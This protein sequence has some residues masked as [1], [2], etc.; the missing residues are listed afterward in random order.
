M[1]FFLSAKSKVDRARVRDWLSLAFV[2]GKAD[3]KE[4]ALIALLAKEHGVSKADVDAALNDPK[5]I[6]PSSIGSEEEQVQHI[7][8]LIQIMLVDGELHERELDLVKHIA[9]RLGY[10]SSN[11]DRMV[12][13]VAKAIEAAHGKQQEDIPI[14]DQELG[15]FIKTA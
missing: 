9:M 2:D 12:H 5:K 6:K 8:D 4:F 11:V 3:E 13:V 7:F 10:S 14:S 15:E 1:P